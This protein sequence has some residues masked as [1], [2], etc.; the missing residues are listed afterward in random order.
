MAEETN[1]KMNQIIS[2]ALSDEKFK[3][4]LIE[5]PITTLKDNGIQVPLN[6]GIKVVQ[7]TDKLFHLVLP[8][9]SSELTDTDL[10][11]IA[12]GFITSSRGN[13]KY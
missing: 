8:Y 9:R 12:G 2:Q 7:N 1:N 13:P 11:N 10:D 3:A 4:E 6:M 5:N